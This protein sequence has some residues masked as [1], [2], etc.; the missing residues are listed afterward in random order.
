MAIVR[1]RT[2]PCRGRPRAWRRRRTKTAQDPMTCERALTGV[3]G[4]RK[5]FV[6]G[7]AGCR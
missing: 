3:S 1:R 2:S 6:Q 7:G 5:T 4:W